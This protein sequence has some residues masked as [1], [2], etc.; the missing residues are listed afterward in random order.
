MCQ[1]DYAIIDCLIKLA[2]WYR[3]AE[4]PTR[5]SLSEGFHVRR[6]TITCY[7]PRRHDVDASRQGNQSSLPLWNENGE[8][9]V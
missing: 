3:Q 7:D 9:E 6:D 5:T 4:L 8:A 1:K 2:I